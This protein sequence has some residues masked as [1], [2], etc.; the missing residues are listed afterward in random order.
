M[1]TEKQIK[2]IKD[3]VKKAFKGQSNFIEKFNANVSKID[4]TSISVMISGLRQELNLKKL[5]CSLQASV[6]SAS[7]MNDFGLPKFMNE[8]SK[9]LNLTSRAKALHNT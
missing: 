5:P 6:Y 1:A 3:L 7:N 9:Y 8:Y 4:S 2:Y